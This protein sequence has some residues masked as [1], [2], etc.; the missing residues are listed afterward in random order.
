MNMLGGAS[1]A[2]KLQDILVKAIIKANDKKGLPPDWME[3][4]FGDALKDTTIKSKLLQ[5][6]GE[7]P[8]E[9][10]PCMHDKPR[11]YSIEDIQFEVSHNIPN[12]YIGVLH[13]DGRTELI[14]QGEVNDDN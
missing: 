8:F 5:H 12:G 6:W 4:I 10:I 9:K 3:D 1:R 11:N 2:E 7:R 13:P 14:K